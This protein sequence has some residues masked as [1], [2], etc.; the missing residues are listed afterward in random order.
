M[1][2]QIQDTANL[3]GNPVDA[4]NSGTAPTLD[5][6][7][8]SPSEGTTEGEKLPDAETTKDVRVARALAMATKKERKAAERE[9]QA[10]AKVRQADERAKQAE[11]ARDEFT[12]LLSDAAK[13]PDKAM[14]LLKKAGIPSLDALARLVLQLAPEPES[15]DKVALRA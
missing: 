10:E 12:S 8:E 11:T 2:D 4:S 7:S 3:P 13:N 5:P 14:T 9:R 15:T 1:T 6:S